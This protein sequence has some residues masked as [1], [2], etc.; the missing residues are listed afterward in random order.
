MK[1]IHTPVLSLTLALALATGPAL[2]SR[3]SEEDVARLGKDLTPMGAIRAANADGLIPEWT[4]TIVGLPEGMSWDGPGTPYPDPYAGEKPLFTIT[5]DNL[6]LYRNRLS[7]GEIA[8]FETYPD[9]F[10]MPV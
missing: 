5:R 2:A 9:T 3:M 10:R 7:P 8:L 6:D 4:G 1:S